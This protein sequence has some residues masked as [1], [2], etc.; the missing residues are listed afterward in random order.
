MSIR[1]FLDQHGLLGRHEQRDVSAEDD[2][3]E[4]DIDQLALYQTIACPYCV[5]VRVAISNLDL[6][7]EIR[8]VGLDNGARHELMDGG[9]SLQ[10]PCLR[11]ARDEG[12]VR[13]MYESRDIVAYLERHF[14]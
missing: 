12:D 11:I 10:V 2:D 9:G 3:I 1:R 7:L 5:R 6:E 8:D 14:G 4:V 13:W